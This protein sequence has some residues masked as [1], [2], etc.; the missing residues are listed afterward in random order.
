MSAPPD[1]LAAIGGLL[2]RGGE[3]RRGEDK[4]GAGTGGEGRGWEAKGK[5]GGKVMG[6]K[7]P[8]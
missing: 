1:R 3:E 7:T 5:E 4:G 8:P 2:L 6:E